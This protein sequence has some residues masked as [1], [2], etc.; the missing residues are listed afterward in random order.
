MRLMN[1]NADPAVTSEL[2]QPSQ[3]S[4]EFIAFASALGVLRFGEFKTK[5]GRLSP[6]F[7]NAGLFSCLLYTSRCV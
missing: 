5:A 3:L 6:Y 2:S 4:G 7:F 1:A